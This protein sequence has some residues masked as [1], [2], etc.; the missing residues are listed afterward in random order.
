[1][2]FGIIIMLMF[3]I[4]KIFYYIIMLIV[5]VIIN[6]IGMFCHLFGASSSNKRNVWNVRNDNSSFATFKKKK[7]YDLS[8]S[9]EQFESE[10]DL[11]GLSKED[12]KIAKEERMSPA[13]FIE[14]EERDDDEL[15]TDEWE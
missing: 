9:E 3:Y 15:F 11:W 7:V 6:F 14:A 13:D 5:E 10:A 4:I 2:S 12:R 1:M 8:W